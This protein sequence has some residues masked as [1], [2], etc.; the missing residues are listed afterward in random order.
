MELKTLSNQKYS[1]GCVIQK[2]ANGIY[3]L[4]SHTWNVHN[5]IWTRAK[6]RKSHTCVIC[7]QKFSKTEM[8]RPITNLS[9]RMKRIC[10]D[11]MEN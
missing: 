9:N 6:I 5:Q 11:C 4:T 2:Q 8:Y 7:N 10:I 1:F 3:T